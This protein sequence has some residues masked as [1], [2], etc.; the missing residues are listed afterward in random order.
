MSAPDFD[1]EEVFAPDDYLYF[2]DPRLSAERT[3]GEVELIWR[4][5]GLEPGMAVLDLACGHGRITN[6]L[7][8][9]GC[10]LV[11]LDSS[12]GFLALA[13]RDAAALAGPGVVAPEY[14]LGDMRRL[15]WSERFDRI[16]N[17]FTA[18]G[19]FDD[20]GN[21]HVL[22]QA[23]RALKPGGKLLVELNNRDAILSHLQHASVVE[24][25][26][27]YMIDQ[28]HYDVP[29][30]RMIT[31]RTVIRDGRVRQM[32]FFVRM[33]TFPELRDWLLA[34]DFSSVEG[35]DEQGGPL[36]LQSRRMLVVATKSLDQ[37]HGD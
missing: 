31:Q 5:L 36:A 34:A 14:V 32:R 7:A 35:F 16:L 13:R 11:G 10:L 37:H 28:T 4:L 30:G 1:F 19:Y 21:R 8:R 29:S 2:Y 9:R 22:H 26:G 12:P 3:D 17:W 33:F 27:N 18:F 15:P 6:R 25:E 24:R 23:Q 20:E